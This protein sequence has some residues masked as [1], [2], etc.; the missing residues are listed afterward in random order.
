MSQSL[1]IERKFEFIE[2]AFGIDQRS[3]RVPGTSLSRTLLSEEMGG[4]LGWVL[5][6]GRMGLPKC[7]FYAKT[8]N[9]CFAKARNAANKGRTEPPTTTSIIG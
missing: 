1:T 6:V 4:D 8:I 3:G 9:G 2:R 5:S 7:H